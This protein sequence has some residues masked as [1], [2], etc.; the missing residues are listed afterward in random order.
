[1]TLSYDLANNLTSVTDS[2]GGTVT[3]TYD[4]ANRITEKQFAD[5]SSHALSVGYTYDSA[6]RLTQLSRYSDA[7]ETTLIGTTGYGYDTAN[8]VTSITHANDSGTTLDSYTYTYNAAGLVATVSSTLGPSATYTYDAAGQLLSDG[9]TS[10]AFDAN[11][12]RN[13]G[14]YSTNTE[15]ELTTD[16]AWNYSYDNAG[17]LAQKT[18]ISTGEVWL[19]TYNNA[20]QLTL[21]QHKPSSTG[22]VNLSV[23]YTYDVLG[24][25]IEQVVDPDGTGLHDV[26]TKYAYDQDANV[27]ADLNSSGTLIARRIF[28]A[29]ADSLIARIDS[30]GV[31]WYL[32]D[33]LGSVRDI[34]NS[35]GS[36]LDHRD[37]NAWGKLAYESNAAYG[38]RFGFTGRPLDTNTQLQN[39]RERWYDPT[40]SR[41]I[42]QD[43]LGLAAGDSNLYRYVSNSPVDAT[44]PSGEIIGWML[45]GGVLG[46]IFLYPP[47][48]NPPPHRPPDPGNP[49]RGAID[50][51]MTAAA[52]RLLYLWCLRGAVS[53]LRGQV[54]T[55]GGM[56]DAARAAG[57]R[58]RVAELDAEINGLCNVIIR[59]GLQL[60]Q[61][62]R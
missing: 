52:L 44:D 4:A 11:G 29:Q 41:W 53:Y 14:S 34:V 45:V 33:M 7:S 50:G 26:T 38:D 5:T 23:Q 56:R 2:L 3:N 17:N 35:T 48:V 18:N 46:A 54:Q 22:T 1:M 15:N 62:M 13:N 37:Y 40:T 49:I 9:T 51:M 6:N 28:G 57:N 39:N 59:I 61:W 58:A 25:L 32:T 47:E 12:N 27:W 42:S 36:I 31:G 43:P 16:G 55:L 8:R 20:N 10:Y 24:N 19:Y 30:N 60:P 21:A